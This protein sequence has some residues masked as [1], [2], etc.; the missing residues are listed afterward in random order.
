MVLGGDRKNGRIRK[1]KINF[2]H[3]DF[4]MTCYRQEKGQKKRRVKQLVKWYHA[5]VQEKRKKE[6]LYI[7][8]YISHQLQGE[9]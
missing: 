4:L 8:I 5:M 3:V 1:K 6:K 2:M 7:Y 9:K